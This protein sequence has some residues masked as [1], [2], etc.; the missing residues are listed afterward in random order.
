MK[1]CL[2]N[3]LFFITVLSCEGVYKCKTNIFKNVKQIYLKTKHL[4]NIHVQYHRSFFVL[5]FI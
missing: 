2:L 3:I 5:F 1:K 4:H